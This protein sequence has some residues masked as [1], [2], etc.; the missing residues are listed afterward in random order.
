MSESETLRAALAMAEA[1][2]VELR[3]AMDDE[4]SKRWGEDRQ[5]AA[6]EEALKRVGELEEKL[7][8]SKQQVIVLTKQRDELLA[9]MR[10]SDHGKLVECYRVRYEA[11]ERSARV[12]RDSYRCAESWSK[13]FKKDADDLR[14]K[15][16]VANERLCDSLEEVVVLRG[17]LGLS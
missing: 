13:K 7:E 9:G 3:Q 14:K 11:Q 10:D 16:G 5:R 4:Q 12:W 2:M 15:L 8:D 6:K 1:E 17:K